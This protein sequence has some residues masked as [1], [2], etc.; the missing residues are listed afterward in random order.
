M[1]RFYSTSELSALTGLSPRQP[2][3]IDEQ[4]ILSPSNRNSWGVLDDVDRRYS[5]ADA[6][7]VALVAL[8]RRKHISLQRIRVHIPVV[9]RQFTKGVPR[10]IVFSE[11]PSQ[12]ILFTEDDDE[13]L[14]IVVLLRFGAYVVDTRDLY[15]V[16]QEEGR[17]A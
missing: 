17:A 5:Q 15:L 9:R 11:S 12:K 16:L 2:Q 3:W 10:Y 1:T 6:L 13:L 14:Q 7:L 4:R 8:L